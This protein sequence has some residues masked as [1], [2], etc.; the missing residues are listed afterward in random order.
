MKDTIKKALK[1]TLCFLPFAIIGGYF[2]A[3]YAFATYDETMQQMLLDQIGSV[4]MLA[5]ITMVQTVMYAV[6]CTVV[7]YIFA[8][9]TGLIKPLRYEKKTLGITIVVAI[10]CGIVFSS[11][12]WLFGTF[13]PEVAESYK[14]GLLVR[15]LD[16]WIASICYGGVIEELMLRFFMMTMVVFVLWKLFCKKRSKDEIPTAI[17]V[18]ANLICAVLFAAGHLPGTVA[19]FGE[20]TAL[21]LV[22]CFLFNGAFGFVFGELYRRFGIQ[23]A[24]VGHMGTH[25]VS[26]LIWLLFI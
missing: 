11:D 1:W 6:V 23:Y 14:D 3:K 5:I 2:T 19:M 10:I 8:E 16:N 13:I 22:R 15:N 24:F 17:Y 20:L 26:K 7:G 21:I 9:K 18:V 12:Y 25:I 4:E